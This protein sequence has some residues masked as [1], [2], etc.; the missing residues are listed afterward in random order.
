[1][2]LNYQMIVSMYKKLEVSLYIIWLGFVSLEIWLWI[3]SYYVEN[4][5]V[6]VMNVKICIDNWHGFSVICNTYLSLV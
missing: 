6:G 3:K 1:M 2:T 4:L 5:K